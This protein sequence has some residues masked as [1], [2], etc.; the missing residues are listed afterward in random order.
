MSKDRKEEADIVMEMVQESK[1]LVEFDEWWAQRMH[2]IPSIHRKEIIKADF[3][4]R[5]VV[6]LQ[7]MEIFDAALEQYGILL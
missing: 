3:R 6:G 4:G 7:T 1:N 2:R 5:K